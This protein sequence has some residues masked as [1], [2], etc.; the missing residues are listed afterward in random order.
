MTGSP[1]GRSWACFAF[2]RRTNPKNEC[3]YAE[4]R[5]RLRLV[6]ESRRRFAIAVSVADTPLLGMA[7][8]ASR[9]GALE[10][11]AQVCGVFHQPGY[12]RAFS[13][14]SFRSRARGGWGHFAG[15]WPGLA[16]DFSA[17]G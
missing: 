8:L 14:C 10:Q 15:Y 17:A 9:V 4:S 11:Y 7:V 1:T 12:P 3:P 6:P 2:C 5:G 16:P 13:E